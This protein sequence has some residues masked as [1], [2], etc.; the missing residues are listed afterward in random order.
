MDGYMDTWIHGY[1]H[2]WIH[3]YMHG[4]MILD[5]TRLY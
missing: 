2:T 5:D 3:G 1:M 4:W